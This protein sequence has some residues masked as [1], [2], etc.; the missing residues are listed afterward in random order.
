MNFFRQAWQLRTQLPE[1]TV[2]QIDREACRT[3][4]YL[5]DRDP[6]ACGDSHSIDWQRTEQAGG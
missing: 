2:E 1:N 3:F 5:R 6:D 4:Q